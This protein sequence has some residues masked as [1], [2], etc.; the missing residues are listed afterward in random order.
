VYI[1]DG[2]H[3]L[4]LVRNWLLDTGFLVNNSVINKKPLE[5]PINKTTTEFSVCHKLTPEHLSCEGPQRH[6]SHPNNK[7][8]PFKAPYGFFL[9]EQDALLDKMYNTFLSMRC[10]GKFGLQIF[11]KA[12]LMH[13][14]GTK[15][16][17][18]ILQ[19]S[20]IKYLLTS[21]INQDALENLFSQLRSRGGLNHPSPLNALFRLRMIILGKNP[22]IV[23]KQA[24]TTDKNNEEFIIAKSLKHIDSEYR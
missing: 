23:S 21:K 11:Q 22:G 12:I 19:Q 3:I 6:V 18:K 10:V 14:K 4:K 15:L 13:I 9:E 20:G 7:T 5:A 17:F 16:F 8:T 2:P 1:P 24:N